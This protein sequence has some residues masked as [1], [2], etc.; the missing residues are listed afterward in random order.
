[1][2]ERGDR[3]SGI[4]SAKRGGERRLNQVGILKEKGWMLMMVVVVVRKGDA[5][6]LL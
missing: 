5:W 3:V 4:M 6:T 1:M 2:V